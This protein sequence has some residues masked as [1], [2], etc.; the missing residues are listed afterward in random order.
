[1]R[2]GDGNRTQNAHMR[3]RRGRS[4]E[5]Q[6]YR[7]LV[8]NLPRPAKA[9]LVCSKEIGRAQPFRGSRSSACSNLQGRGRLR[10]PCKDVQ[11]YPTGH[12]VQMRDSVPKHTVRISFMTDTHPRTEYLQNPTDQHPTESP[13]SQKADE[14]DY[15]E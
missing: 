14:R 1:M 9:R 5:F 8:G 2:F 12:S 13:P 10:N 11:G 6:T 7:Q 4:S 15:G 3:S